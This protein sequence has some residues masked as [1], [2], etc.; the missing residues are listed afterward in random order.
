M[1]DFVGDEG[2][3]KMKHRLLTSASDLSIVILNSFLNGF[4]PPSCV[5]LLL[6]LN[7]ICQGKGE[8]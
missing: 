6:G 4:R 5:V 8:D 3:K 7:L 1:D 2:K